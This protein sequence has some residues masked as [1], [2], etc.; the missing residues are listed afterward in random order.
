M[1]ADPADPPAACAACSAESAG[2]GL[3]SPADCRSLR[4]RLAR[5]EARLEALMR[6]SSDWFWE[7]DTSLRFVRCAGGGPGA[8]DLG[9]LL[10]GRAPWELPATTP[11]SGE[12]DD[13]HSLLEATR[14]F[15]DFVCVTRALGGNVERRIAFSGEPL[16]A[17]DGRRAGWH[18]LVRDV[19]QAHRA[20]ER[21]RQLAHRDRLT[22]LLNR[23][24]TETAL[25]QLLE[26][27]AT[28]G[29]RVHVLYLDLDGFKAV[30]D[31]LGHAAGDRVLQESANRLRS[32]LRDEDLL[33]RFGGDEF[34][35]VLSGRHAAGGDLAARVC[36]R[37]REAMLPP[38]VVDGVA[39]QLGASIGAAT[40]PEDAAELGALLQLADAA[41]Y[42][43]KRARRAGAPPAADPAAN[44]KAAPA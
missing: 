42:E 8:D 6:L 25:Q 9:R 36:T 3:A 17:S 16:P 11:V 1:T 12:W 30:N 38:I 13:L 20:Q 26:D 23:G 18:G 37:M 19:S 41:M 14:P 5:S 44:L 34:V 24:A 4:E 10:L 35:V 32:V 39:C 40:Y 22:G 28:G 15:A 27:A 21:L 29:F 7:L 43:A 33:G 2:D 31:R